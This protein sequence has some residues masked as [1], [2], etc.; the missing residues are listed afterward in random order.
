MKKLAI[1]GLTMLIVGTTAMSALAEKIPH[2]TPSDPTDTPGNCVPANYKQILR[3]ENLQIP[4]G[5]PTGVNTPP[6]ILPDDGSTITDVQLSLNM[7]HTWIGDLNVQLLYDHDCTPGT[8]PFGPVSVMCRQ[9]LA[10]CPVDMCCGCSGDLIN[11]LNYQFANTGNGSTKEI[12]ADSQGC[13]TTI[14]AGCYTAAVE[15]QFTF[16][17]FSGLRK[18]GCWFMHLQD[19]AGADVGSLNTWTLFVKNQQTTAVE[20]STWGAVKAG[21]TL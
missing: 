11:G 1:A 16:S 20:S 21:F 5:N 7:S 8:P 14:P 10:G 3:V 12:A 9:Q 6:A 17:V 4:D 2:E 18:G 13:P 15:S 19:G